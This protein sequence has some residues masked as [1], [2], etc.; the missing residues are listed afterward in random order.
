M[1]EFP[2]SCPNLFKAESFVDLENQEWHWAE[3][4][5]NQDDWEFKWAFSKPA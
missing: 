2:N 5:I 4:Y 3:E 1:L